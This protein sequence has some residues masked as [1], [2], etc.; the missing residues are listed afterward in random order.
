MKFKIKFYLILL[1]PFLST[2]PSDPERK[3]T[4]EQKPDRKFSPE[5]EK[6]DSTRLL[7]IIFSQI[8]FDDKE[9]TNTPFSLNLSPSKS[10]ISL[11]PKPEEK[12]FNLTLHEVPKE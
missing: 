12:N 3:K 5:K 4:Q 9:K 6:S 2:F 1:I 11:L 8:S 10:R 7:Q